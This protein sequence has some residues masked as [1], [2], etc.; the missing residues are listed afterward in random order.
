[1]ARAFR[2]EDIRPFASLVDQLLSRTRVAV[3]LDPARR[4]GTYDTLELQKVLLSKES[5]AA[6]LA[7]LQKHVELLAAG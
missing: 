5:F 6:F 3:F 4:E 2:T 7:G 1:M